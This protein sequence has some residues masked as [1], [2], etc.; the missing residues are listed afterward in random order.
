MNSQQE[1]SVQTRPDATCVDCGCTDSHACA[2]GCSWSQIDRV[3]KTGVCS[4]CADVRKVVGGET[5]LVK[6]SQLTAL[7]WDRNRPGNTR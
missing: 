4:R 3:E 6:S 2:G 1:Q 7:K 5:V